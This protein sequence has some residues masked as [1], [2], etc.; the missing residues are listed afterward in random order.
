ML[1]A[2]IAKIGVPLEDHR[3]FRKVGARLV[4]QRFEGFVDTRALVFVERRDARAQI[5]ATKIGDEHAPCGEHGS[6]ERH[7]HFAKR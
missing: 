2:P 3:S 7:D 4:R 1:L 6:A 5:V